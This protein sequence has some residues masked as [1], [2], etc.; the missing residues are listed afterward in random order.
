MS[1]PKF[2][3]IKDEALIIKVFDLAHR[4]KT[5]FTMWFKSQSIRFDSR[6]TQ[7]LLYLKRLTFQF[8]VT[9][10]ENEFLDAFKSQ[11]TPEI[12]ASFSID[13]T[14][15]FLKTRYVGMPHPN[16]FQLELP[17]QIY[18]MQR[19]SYVR[20]P[21]TRTTAPKLTILDPRR[22]M[23]AKDT[24][25]PKDYLHFRI[26]D[27]S[28]GGLAIAAPVESKD[29]FNVGAKFHDMRFKIKGAELMADGAVI[30]VFETFSDQKKPMIQIGI[31][32]IHLQQRYEKL[33][34]Q[35]ALD[36][37]RRLFSSLY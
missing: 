11:G 1:K 13:T 10:N 9:V 12:M 5:I 25:T 6:I 24:L 32:F 20:I 26:L 33:I 2:F 35:F 29:I 8:P 3:E 17:Q 34:A 23:D 16:V 15:F 18:K 27:V 22:S 36:E 7:F 21:F 14:N 28:I 31:Q 30:H 37:S 19:R 4:H